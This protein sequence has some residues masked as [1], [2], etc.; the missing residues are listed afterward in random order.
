MLVK[1]KI[2]FIEFRLY[3]I[4]NLIIKMIL[5][6]YFHYI[7]IQYYPLYAKCGLPHLR[8]IEEYVCRFR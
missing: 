6:K 8:K 2:L 4:V 1:I 7:L 3:R 5:H